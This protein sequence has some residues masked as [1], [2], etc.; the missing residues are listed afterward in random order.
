MRQPLAVVIV[1][2]LLVQPAAGS[3]GDA[4]VVPLA[5]RAAVTKRPA[6]SI[7]AEDEDMSAT[8]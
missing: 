2:G 1:S 4:G 5:A 6:A 3:S 7:S 8:G